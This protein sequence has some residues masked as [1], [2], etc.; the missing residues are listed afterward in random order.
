MCI[1]PAATAAVARFC[2]PGESADESNVRT[3][4]VIAFAFPFPFPF[5]WE[6]VV[7]CGVEAGMEMGVG[8]GLEVRR[9]LIRICCC[10]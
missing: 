2:K 4:G 7:D 9:R 3:G 8:G 1:S 6:F 10:G 5:S